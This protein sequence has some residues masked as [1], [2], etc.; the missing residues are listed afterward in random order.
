MT[1]SRYWMRSKLFPRHAIVPCP[2]PPSLDLK[3]L[4]WAAL[5]VGS[6][7][8]VLRLASDE[9]ADPLHYADSGEQFS[10]AEY[11]RIPERH[12]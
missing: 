12:Q 9:I 6:S 11:S 3:M 7:L 10:A 4:G 8:L 1:A 5:R 2:A